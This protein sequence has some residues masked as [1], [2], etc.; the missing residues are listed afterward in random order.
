M[1]FFWMVVSLISIFNQCDILYY[2]KEAELKA[3]EEEDRICTEA[4]LKNHHHQQQQQ[5]EQLVND[6]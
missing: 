2:D 6:I 1:L 4:Q 3:Q 5:Q